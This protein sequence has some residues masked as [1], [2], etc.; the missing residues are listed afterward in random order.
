MKAVLIAILLLIASSLFAQKATYVPTAPQYKINGQAVLYEGYIISRDGAKA[1]TAKREPAGFCFKYEARLPVLKE[2]DSLVMV[3]FSGHDRLENDEFF[4]IN[5]KSIGKETDITLDNFDLNERYTERGWQDD[6]M[7][8]EDNCGERETDSDEESQ[9]TGDEY[10]DVA[11]TLITKKEFLKM[12]SSST[13]YLTVDKTIKKKG[14]TLTIGGQKFTDSVSEEGELLTNEYTYI[15]DYKKLN[16]SLLEYMCSAC[17]EYSY[18]LIDR[19]T[20]KQIATFTNVPV[21]SK[22]YKY[23][24][25]LGQLFS[26]N[27]TILSCYKWKDRAKFEVPGPGT[28]KEFANWSPVGKGFWGKDNCFYTPVVPA[29]TIDNHNADEAKRTAAAYNYRY[30]KITIKGPTPK[31]EE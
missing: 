8:F 6:N 19:R 10:P 18:E 12:K 28:Y 31:Q 3:A 13:D 29:I 25:D 20:G 17:E 16:A 2:T 27:P 21:F 30:V 7:S 1:Y 22:N 5:K 26:S 11:V 24:M 23:V 4:Y 15:G 14:N 9:F